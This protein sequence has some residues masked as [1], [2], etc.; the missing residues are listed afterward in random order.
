M[1]ELPMDLDSLNKWVGAYALTNKETMIVRN[2]EVIDIYLKDVP[3]SPEYMEYSDLIYPVLSE[4][5]AIKNSGGGKNDCLII[6]FLMGVSENYRKLSYTEKYVVSNEFRRNVLPRIIVSAD[7]SELGLT[8]KSGTNTDEDVK[9]RVDKII[10]KLQDY[11]YLLEN[12]IN[13]LSNLYKIFIVTLEPG[14]RDVQGSEQTYQPPSIIEN[15]LIINKSNPLKIGYKIPE[16]YN[17]GII[18]CNMNNNGHFE[19]LTKDNKYLF[20]RPEILDFYHVID[21]NNP[22]KF[23]PLIENASNEAANANKNLAAAKIASLNDKIRREEENNLKKAIALSREKPISPP[24]NSNLFN[25]FHTPNSTKKEISNTTPSSSENSNNND[26]PNNFDNNTANSPNKSSPNTTP[27]SSNIRGKL[28]N[29]GLPNITLP[30]SRNSNTTRNLFFRSNG[31][32]NPRNKPRNLTKFHPKK[33]E[34]IERMRRNTREKTRRFRGYLNS[35]PQPSR[36][37]WRNWWNTTIRRKK[38]SVHPI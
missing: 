5:K 24:F 38:A 26:Y 10:K 12:I 9:K 29:N 19:I 35:L 37:K 11:G 14:K 23:K 32:I 34:Q 25:G 30:S 17:H 21:N 15:G 33:R 1:A 7:K 4:Y 13:L 6:S 22:Y 31:L 36:R 16:V 27:P 3:G 18:I 28:R 8:S 20:D 2:I